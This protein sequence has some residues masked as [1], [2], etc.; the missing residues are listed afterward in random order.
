MC[1]W[2]WLPF[3]KAGHHFLLCNALW[4]ALSQARSLN[5]KNRVGTTLQT[6]IVDRLRLFSFY[7][8]TRHTLHGYSNVY[9]I[10]PSQITSSAYLLCARACVFY[11][12]RATKRWIWRERAWQQDRKTNRQTCSCQWFNFLPTAHF[13]L[14]PSSGELREMCPKLELPL[15]G[16]AKRQENR[17]RVKGN[18]GEELTALHFT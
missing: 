3:N 2:G 9:L 13:L 4:L 16:E 15:T 18:T 5:C 11:R 8:L 10:T 17:M 1:L 7:C 14:F 6:K 12:G